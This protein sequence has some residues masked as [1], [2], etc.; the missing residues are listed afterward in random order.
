MNRE[1]WWQWP[2]RKVPFV[3]RGVELGQLHGLLERSG[4]V[5]LIGPTGIG[6]RALALEY[7][8]RFADRHARPGQGGCLRWERLPAIRSAPP[9]ATEV[10]L[11]VLDG[12]DGVGEDGPSQLAWLDALTGVAQAAPLTRI[13]V[14]MNLPPDVVVRSGFATLAVP[15]LSAEESL[16]LLVALSGRHHVS[17]REQQAAVALLPRLQ[18]NPAA[19]IKLAVH[20]VATRRSWS[21]CLH[22]APPDADGR[23]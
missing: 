1:P 10:G 9:A 12:E 21:D 11:L 2:A 19:V 22:G 23:L 14:A 4:R 20:A 7:G 5:V 18:G 3:G 8:Y 13:V 6:K 16:A 17:A 15:P